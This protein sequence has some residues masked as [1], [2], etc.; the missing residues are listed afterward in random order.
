MSVYGISDRARDYVRRR[1]TAVMSATCRIERVTPP[2]FNQSTGRA[3][4][5]SKT[6][7]YE[8]RCRIWEVSA[9]QAPVM[10]GEE[11]IL[12]PTTQLSIPWDVNPV[13]G[14]R[15]QVEI[16]DHDSDASMIGQRYEIQSGAKAGDLRATRRFLIQGYDK[17]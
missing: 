1:A 6:T 11:D 10:V 12:M 8:G 14:R 4:T 16:I 15:D 5:G 2:V 17:R 3:T 9:A 7:I 13:P